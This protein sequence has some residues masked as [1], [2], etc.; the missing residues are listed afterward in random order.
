MLLPRTFSV[1]DKIHKGLLIEA[2]SI[3]KRVHFICMGFHLSETLRVHENIT[4]VEDKVRGEISLSLALS[5]ALILQAL[6]LT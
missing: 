6:A 3:W 1:A 4:G 2:L 5:L